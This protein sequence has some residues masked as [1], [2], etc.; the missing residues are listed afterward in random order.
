MGELKRTALFDLHERLGGKIVAFAGWEL[1]VQYP[2]GVMKEHLHAREAAGLFDVSHMGQVIVRA[3]AAALEALMP[4]DVAGLAE[5]RQRYGLFTNATGGIMDDLMFANRGD[6]FFLVVNA[7]NAEADIAH[8]ESH[9]GDAVEPITN[10]ALLALQGPKAADAL[11]EI[12]PSVRDMRFMDVAVLDSAFGAV[13]VSRSGYT[14]D[15]GFEISVPRDQATA[16]AET[17]LANDAVAPI[18][19]GARDSLRME[20]GLPLHGHEMT[21]ETTP[22]TAGVG[23]AISK[24]RRAGG[25][26]EGGFPGSDVILPELQN[27]SAQTTVGLLPEGRAPVRDG[28]PVFAPDSDRQIGIVTSGGFAPSLGHPIS[29]ARIDADHAAPE[30]VVHAEVRGKR[31]PAR[32]TKLPFR[33]STFKR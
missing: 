8:L 23:W 11:A 25:A 15:D 26:R 33:P 4:V 14:G 2:M 3:D 32:V 17:L 16:F 13:W 28:A 29:I 18:G 5:G 30:T 19:L 12:I 24:S 1:P 9:L 21:E 22:K 6:H 7:A 10:R 31:L 27:G 20:A